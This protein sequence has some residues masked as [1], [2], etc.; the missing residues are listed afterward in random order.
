M[1]NT[2]K[3]TPGPWKAYSLKDTSGQWF[4]EGPD[5]EICCVSGAGYDNKANAQLI[6]AAPEMFG[7]LEMLWDE[8]PLNERLSWAAYQ[9]IAQA[10]AKAKGEV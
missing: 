1:T 8:I 7:A 9:N 6:A 5:V 10:I 4:V 3:H 2:P